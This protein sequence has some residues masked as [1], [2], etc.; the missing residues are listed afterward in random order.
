[1][2]LSIIQHSMRTI[3]DIYMNEMDENIFI[4]IWNGKYTLPH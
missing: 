3:K 1:M 4:D 2:L